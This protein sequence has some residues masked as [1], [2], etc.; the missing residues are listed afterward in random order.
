MQ[1]QEIPFSQ[2]TALDTRIFAATFL[3]ASSAPKD[4]IPDERAN[5]DRSSPSILQQGHRYLLGLACAG[6]LAGPLQAC[7]S[8]DRDK[9]E[10]I[11][12]VKGEEGTVSIYRDQQ[13]RFSVAGIEG[14]YTRVEAKIIN[15]K[16]VVFIRHPNERWEVFG[17]DKKSLARGVE[18][19]IMSL[20]G[21]EFFYV[22]NDEWEIRT[23]DGKIIK[24]YSKEKVAIEAA[25]AIAMH[26]KSKSECKDGS[27][28]I[29]R[30]GGSQ[31]LIDD[32][33][34]QLWKGKFISKMSF[35]GKDFVYIS[36]DEGVAIGDEQGQTIT[37]WYKALDQET[38]NRNDDFLLVQR[39]NNA[40]QL[41]RFS[42]KQPVTED[43]TDIEIVKFRGREVLHVTSTDGYHQ[44]LD[45]RGQ[46]LTKK[47]KLI[48]L[49]KLGNDILV[50]ELENGK[51]QLLRSD[52]TP[53][54]GECVEVGGDT[55]GTE[56]AFILTLPNG[57]QTVVKMDETRPI[58]PKPAVKIMMF[59]E[60]TPGI[61]V[62]HPDGNE[63]VLALQDGKP[64]TKSY[65]TLMQRKS[66]WWGENAGR[67]FEIADNPEL[68]DAIPKLL[69]RLHI[70]DT[71]T[72]NDA[73]ILDDLLGDETNRETLFDETERGVILYLCS[74]M[75]LA[76][77][78]VHINDLP[79]MIDFDQ[80]NSVTD[81][82]RAAEGGRL[83]GKK[84]VS[85]ALAALTAFF[86]P[87]I[88]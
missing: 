43:C 32:N 87:P 7:S 31:Y 35:G 26:E 46:P 36:S 22:N 11:Q 70:A 72:K 17:L 78:P 74:I 54:T 86:E 64:L 40:W 21:K 76:G 48:S 4:P 62:K 2:G 27:L 30:A 24:R 15:R 5:W 55:F 41:Q 34:H 59:H 42:T 29:K 77:I 58:Q 52:E 19:T 61:W 51:L 44:L 38:L 23:D 57:W 37:P 53:M 56:A 88:Q 33:G 67:G 1:S 6:A 63:Q 10:L 50:V 83:N 9:E 25:T 79:A 66:W 73:I 45:D 80:I 75:K 8:C 16:N 12:F 3:A 20:N 85:E 14:K 13:G 65:K 60:D 39:E 28:A 49:P 69:Q 81:T 84:S 82:E 71:V 47:Y 18:I 68:R